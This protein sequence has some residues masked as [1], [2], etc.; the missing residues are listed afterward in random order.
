MHILR[1]YRRPVAAIAIAGVLGLSI[2]APA[3]HAALVTTED[4]ATPVTEQQRARV[5]AFLS[6]A[7][8]RAEMESLGV[9]AEE[10]EARVAALSDDE[11][12][13]ISGKLDELPAGQG[14]GAVL[15]AAVLVFLV[16][17]LTDI[18]GFTHVFGFTNKGSAR[19][20]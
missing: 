12:A 16:L 17:L 8:V 6:R 10:A 7:D 19:A 4:T 15:G 5:T 9:S 11:V 20:N 3:A 14:F 13:R 1:I 18:L 2:P